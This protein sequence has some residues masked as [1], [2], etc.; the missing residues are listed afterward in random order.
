MVLVLVV[1]LSS[2]EDALE[3]LEVPDVRLL[4]AV[5]RRGLEFLDRVVDGQSELTLEGGRS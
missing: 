2:I 4:V 3:R 5:A 1:R